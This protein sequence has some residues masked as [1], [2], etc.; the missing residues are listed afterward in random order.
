MCRFALYLGN[1]AIPVSALVTEPEHSLIHQSYKSRER[2][3]PLNGDGF[4]IAWY[5]DADPEPALFKDISPAWSNANLRHLARVTRSRCIL[6][7]VRAATA[8]LPVTYTNC[9]P[10]E[11]GH[12][13][14]M[15]NG[16]LSCFTHKRR[17]C[18][19]MLSDR[20]YGI[21]KGTTDSEFLFALFLDNYW[22]LANIEEPLQRMQQGLSATIEQVASLCDQKSYGT[23]TLNLVVADGSRAVA[24]RY[25]DGTPEEANSLYVQSGGSYCCDDGHCSMETQDNNHRS[26]IITSEGLNDDP[27]WQRVP[28]NHFVTVDVELEVGIT[29]I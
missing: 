6:A 19:A 16:E 24:S 25:T 14:F 27:R 23:S 7:H 2:S 4:G 9:H 18:L 3:E 11:E 20:A 28:V 8:G 22:K 12:L 13:S 29:E 10:F 15:H 1:Q 5:A 17:Q 21:I 26:V